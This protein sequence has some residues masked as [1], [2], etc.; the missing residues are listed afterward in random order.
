MGIISHTLDHAAQA[1][2]RLARQFRTK[3]RIAAL[4]EAFATEVQLFEDAV[5]ELFPHVTFGVDNAEGVQLDLLGAIVGQVRGSSVND[6]EYRTRIKARVRARLSSG[7]VEEV[8]AV[9]VALVGAT[10]VIVATDAPPAG[11]DLE[12]QEVAV[13][14]V[15]APLF[16]GFL[17][18]AKAAAVYGVFQWFEGTE[19]TSF[20]FPRCAFLHGSLAGGETLVAGDDL[21]ALGFPAAG[22]LLIDGGTAVAETWDYQSRTASEMT[23]SVAVVNAHGTRAVLE[24]TAVQTGPA[25]WVDERGEGAGDDDDVDAGGEL[26]G[27]LGA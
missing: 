18:D 1:V 2:A 21:D 24:L 16:A 8:L 14:A 25:T 11:F 9:F 5:Y 10:A 26:A 27:A 4:V 3:A 7:A 13:S 15:N 20:V 19:A 23:G 6:A 17:H 12:I 22:R